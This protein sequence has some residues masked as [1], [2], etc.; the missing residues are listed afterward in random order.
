MN[1]A[2]RAV[3]LVQVAKSLMLSAG[4][5]A[6]ETPR[7]NGDRYFVRLQVSTGLQEFPWDILLPNLLVACLSASL[8]ASV[9]LADVPVNLSIGR[10]LMFGFSL[11]ELS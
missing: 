9:T 3:P 7:L 6:F 4:S 8:I 1:V 5:R 11:A 2:T 10:E